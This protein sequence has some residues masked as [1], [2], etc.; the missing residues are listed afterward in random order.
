MEMIRELDELRELAKRG[1]HNPDEWKRI[2]EI[3]E[4]AMD[5]IY[6]SDQLGKTYAALFKKYE[7]EEPAVHYKDGSWHCPACE[8]R[9]HP[10]AHFC[11]WCGKR[12][13]KDGGRHGQ[14][15]W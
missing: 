6:D 14:Q 7:V 15:D 12:L 4:A 3:V 8:K 1:T 9:V 13:R 11:N 2:N 10:M 5:I